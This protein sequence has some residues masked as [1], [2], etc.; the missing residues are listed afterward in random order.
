M[1]LFNQWVDEKARSKISLSDDTISIVMSFLVTFDI[2]GMMFGGVREG[3]YEEFHL[4]SVP[5]L[6]CT[7]H[8]GLIEGEHCVFTEKG[9]LEISCDYVGGKKHGKLY[10]YSRH[11]IYREFEFED[12]IE[13]GFKEYNKFGDI[14][15]ESDYRDSM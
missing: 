7:Y 2:H 6:I 13:I 4:N 8:N 9:R 15:Y 12:D 14:T 5:S 3:R 1:E 10:V 11:G